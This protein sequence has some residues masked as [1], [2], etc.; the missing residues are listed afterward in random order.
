MRWTASNFIFSVQTL[1]NG[2]ASND[3]VVQ[4]KVAMQNIREAMLDSLCQP[5]SLADHT[6]EL[7]VVHANDL[8]ELWYLRGDLMAAMAAV[9]GEAVARRKLIQISDMF[10]GFL[11]KGLTSRPTPLGQ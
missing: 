10:K 4:C 1:F 2:N 3:K 8:Q 11:P 7:K 9:D 5:G 6:V